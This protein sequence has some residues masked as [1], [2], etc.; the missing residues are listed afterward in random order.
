[1]V[2]LALKTDS[3]KA[4][5]IILDESGRRL[6]GR[7]WTAGR[8]LEAELFRVIDRQLKEVPAALNDIGGVVVFDGP[9]SFTGLRIGVAAANA[10]AYG[11]GC[12][13]VG[14]HGSDWLAGGLAA[15]GSGQPASH[16]LVLPEYGREPNISSPKRK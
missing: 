11:L 14:S 15:L 10:L 7:T 6:A 13:V 1:M 16:S 2:I 12:P 5:V 8:S 3:D 4:S 9:G